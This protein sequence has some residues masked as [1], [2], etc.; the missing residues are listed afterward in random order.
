MLL[1]QGSLERLAS[2]CVGFVRSEHR[3]D[4]TRFLAEALEK[5]TPAELKGHLNRQKPEI[6]MQSAAAV[7]FL[8]YAFKRLD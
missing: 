7:A 3:A 4:L 6:I 2:D 5:Q 1:A 8:E